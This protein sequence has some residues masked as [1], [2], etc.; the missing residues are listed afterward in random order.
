MRLDEF[1]RSAPYEARLQLHYE[2][3]EYL[4]EV[5]PG[6]D[7][8]DGDICLSDKELKKLYGPDTRPPMVDPNQA[9]KEKLLAKQNKAA[10]N[11]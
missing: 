3:I 1:C 6:I 9:F 2:T 4:K 11:V 5:M 7:P 10:R 8:R